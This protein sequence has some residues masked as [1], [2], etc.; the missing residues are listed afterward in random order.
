MLLPLLLHERVAE[1]RLVH[2][3]GLEPQWTRSRRR[4]ESEKEATCL[5][6]ASSRRKAIQHRAHTG[7]FVVFAPPMELSQAGRSQTAENSRQL[8]LPPGLPR[9]SC[10]SPGCE[11]G[12][13]ER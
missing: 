7:R 5:L 10:A 9:V 12:A 13:P 11:P 8:G 3:R 1:V 6:W 2:N 4:L